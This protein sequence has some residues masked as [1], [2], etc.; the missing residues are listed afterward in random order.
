MP[1]IV[2]TFSVPAAE[3][4]VAFTRA[5]NAFEKEVKDADTRMGHK[6]AVKMTAMGESVYHVARST[7]P[8]QVQR[9]FIFQYDKA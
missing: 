4:D 3:A 5:L 9:T 8:A 2:K 6:S 7:T 1:F